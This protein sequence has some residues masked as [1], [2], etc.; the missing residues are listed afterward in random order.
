MSSILV[1]LRLGA[2]SR[3]RQG[4]QRSDDQF[5]SLD[6]DTLDIN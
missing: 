5:V 3:S 1:G 2:S 4:N 6:L